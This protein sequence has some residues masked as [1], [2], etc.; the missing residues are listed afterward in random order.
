M[1]IKHASELNRE[2]MPMYGVLVYLILIRLDELTWSEFKR[3]VAAY[4]D[5]KMVF[6]MKLVLVCYNA[7]IRF[8]FLR[9]CSAR[10]R[11]AAFARKV[12]EAVRLQAKQK[13]CLF[14]LVQSLFF[15][16]LCVLC[17]RSYDVQYVDDVLI[18]TLRKYQQEA[19]DLISTLRGRLTGTH[20]LFVFAVFF[21]FTSAAKTA[22]NQPLIF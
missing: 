16:V 11:G 4:E 18:G 6:G 13:I 2:D 7:S 21:M 15:F 20:L 22:R 17:C 19:E 8:R 5:I 1:F 9:S 14:L 10:E 3:F 12:D